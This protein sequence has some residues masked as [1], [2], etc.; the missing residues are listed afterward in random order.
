MEPI[1]HVLLALLPVGAYALVRHRRLPSGP[2]VLTAVFAGLFA[3]IVDKP[4]AWTFGLVPS[5]RMVAHSLV[6]SLPLL[7]CLLVIAYRTDRLHYGVAFTWGHLAHIAGDF[8]PL[9][10]QGRSYYYG[11]NLFWPLKQANPDR[12]PGFAN[13][14]PALGVELLAE[15]AVLALILAYVAVDIRHTLR[16]RARPS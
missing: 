12:N 10:Q 9:L 16:K 4:L 5:G 2:L 7:V 13:H 15:L 8:Y 6:I 1:N 3:D 14:T 11:P